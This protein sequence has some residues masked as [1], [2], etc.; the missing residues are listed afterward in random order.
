MKSSINL[1][2]IEEPEA[3]THPQMQY[4]FINNIKSIIKK[5]SDGINLNTILTTHSPQIVSQS[6][7]ENILCFIRN[8]NESTI[9]SLSKFMSRLNDDKKCFD[10]VKKYLTLTNSEIFFADKVII[11][12]GTTER[13]LLPVFIKI[14]DKNSPDLKLS[15]QN[16]SIIESG[17]YAKNLSPLL[18]FLEVKTL[19]ITDIDFI[20]KR[21]KKCRFDKAVSTSNSTIKF[22]MDNDFSKIKNQENV[23]VRCNVG[24]T[25][26]HFD[27]GYHARSF[28]DAYISQNYE[29]INNNL[30]KFKSIKCKNHFKTPDYYDLADNCIKEKSS[31][32]AEIIYNSDM[33]FSDILVPNYIK[34]G[35]LWLREQ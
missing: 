11:I 20:N 18:E 14:L 27:N 13:I 33:E 35:L 1:L 32:A 31:F 10:Y 15:S 4:V 34:D 29:F 3:H 19:I 26:Q 2:I 12:E 30:D 9:K 7:Y 5:Y 6:N 22:Y 28:E 25:F 17:S 24:L 8:N 23:F 16:I 21:G